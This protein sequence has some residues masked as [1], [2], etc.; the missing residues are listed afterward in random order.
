[1]QRAA[2]YYFLHLTY[3]EH[4]ARIDPGRFEI[5]FFFSLKNIPSIRFLSP[6]LSGCTNPGASDHTIYIYSLGEFYDP[7]KPSPTTD[8]GR[9]GHKTSHPTHNYRNITLRAFNFEIKYGFPLAVKL[10]PLGSQLTEN[11]RNIILGGNLSSFLLP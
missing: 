10:P 9:K 11:H 5:F 6:R 7:S 4:G 1:M 3:T 8:L 2:L